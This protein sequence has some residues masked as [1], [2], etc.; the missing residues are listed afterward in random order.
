M[1]AVQMRSEWATFVGEERD[2][3][4][5]D[6][7]VDFLGDHGGPAGRRP[8]NSSFGG[9]GLRACGAPGVAAGFGS[10][11]PGWATRTRRG[12]TSSPGYCLSWPRSPRWWSQVC[13]GPGGG[14]RG[15]ACR[16]APRFCSCGGRGS[17][18][19]TGTATGAR[20]A[21]RSTRPGR[22]PCETAEPLYGLQVKS[23][24][25]GQHFSA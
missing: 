15:P 22:G 21:G 1:I 11:R 20:H 4:E 14:C 8:L 7:Q 25:T 12:V 13:C 16:Q 2:S 24:R 10:S 17:R 19:A 9:G 23:S 6:V 5:G 3:D 18:P